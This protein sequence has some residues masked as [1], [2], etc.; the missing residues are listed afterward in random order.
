MS[1][2][3]G[4]FM[5][6]R[7]RAARN[8]GSY[9]WALLV[10]LGIGYF[11]VD[12]PVL[13][14]V[15]VGAFA[16]VCILGW[17]TRSSTS[18][19]EKP[20]SA[21]KGGEE[22]K[23]EAAAEPITGWRLWVFRLICV[24]VIPAVVILLL[25]LGLRAGG[26]GYSPA[27]IVKCEVEGRERYCDNIKFGRRFFPYNIS[28]ELD[29]F[30][31]PVEKGENSY[32][33]FVLGA[34]A[35]KGIPMEAFSFSRILQEMLRQEY[36][37]VNFE[38][39]NMGMAA[40]NSHV[41][42]EIAED[43]ART[44]PDLFIVYLG[45]NEVVGPYGAG[46]V[47]APLSGNLSLIRM[48]IALK[49]TRLGQLLVGLSK[50]VGAGKD[51]PAIWRGLEMYLEKQVRA[52]DERLETVYHHFQRNLEDIS[53][54][55]RESGAEVIFCTVGSNLRDSPPFASLHRE[56]L[57][58]AET[59][60]WEEL[61][62]EGAGNETAGKYTEAVE[63]YLAACKIDDSY[64]DLQ[65][66]LGRC[67]WG[68]G[69][70]DKALER[71]TEAR[72]QDTLRFRA[73]RRINEIIRKVAV[74]GGGE[75]VYLVDGV[76]VFEQGSPQGIAGEELFYEHVHLTF[77]GNYLLA[78]AILRQVVGIFPER[79]RRHKSDTGSVL[80][81]SEC[82]G[83]LAYTDW[84]RYKIYGNVLND[85]IKKPPFTN[86]LYHDEE[87]RQKEE[88]LKRLETDMTSQALKDSA[89]QYRRAIQRDNRDWYLHY[90]YGQI[91][92]EDMEDYSAAVEEY[93]LV[94]KYFPHSWTGYDAMGSVLRGRGDFKGAIAQFE[95]AIQINPARAQ[96]HYYLG[97]CYQKLGRIDKAKEYYLRTTR[98]RPNAVRAYNDI[99]QILYKQG[100]VAEAVK[101]IRKGLGF[102]PDS[103]V[104]HRNLGVLLY[105]QGRRDEA[106]KELRRA[107]E[108]DPNSVE[109][110]TVL[111]KIQAKPY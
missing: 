57:S 73:D 17:G 65:F 39:I 11:F 29:P 90:K 4:K 86:Q 82:A 3:R 88:N 23:K 13:K 10:L 68:M 53:R 101:I 47:F 36:P 78:R 60:R 1:G 7:G 97:W 83:R 70:Y 41:V 8:R 6:R 50:S 87:V 56:D 37:G 14:Y 106:I 74:Q 52:D 15:I 26:Y 55:A 85:F 79:V 34:S 108:I 49:G 16:L 44:E 38:V 27:A 84:D 111:E 105:A 72:R 110:R 63:Q 99:G 51:Q 109:T 80:T 35:A 98:L 22:K 59:K 48:G 43:C 66:R 9:W 19:E 69:D 77:R 91:L 61:Y 18:T 46:T 93:R 31:L 76:E 100:K 21:G 25:E 92:A 28:R 58:G 64:A 102:V 94:Q 33:I 42:L 103:V 95:K 54:V 104:L 5:S 32:R 62:E 75:G 24:V 89:A 67:F 30:V 20:A 45:N 2:I 40:I 12:I 107:L 81:E 96:T 71:Y